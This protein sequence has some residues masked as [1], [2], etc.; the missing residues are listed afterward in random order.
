MKKGMGTAIIITIFMGIIIFGYGY[1][2]VF[3]LLSSETPL[4]FII[5]AIL[6]FVTIMW[7]LIINLIERI[8]EIRE[9][10]KDD[11]SKY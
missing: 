8:K 5:I 1:A 11:L 3:G 9:E 2:L 4:I 10:D 7:A 6:I